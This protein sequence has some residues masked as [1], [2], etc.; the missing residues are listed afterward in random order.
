MEKTYQKTF[1]AGWGD[2]DFNSHMRNTAYLDKSAD[3]RMV[4]FSEHGF[5]M[6]EFVRLKIGPVII[7]DEMGIVESQ[8]FLAVS[9]CACRQRERLDPDSA[10]CRHPEEV[11]LHFKGLARYLVG[12]DLGRRIAQQDHGSKAGE[13]TCLKFKKI[14]VYMVFRRFGQVAARSNYYQNLLEKPG[15]THGRP[16]FPEDP[17]G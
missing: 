14:E 3:T 9:R 6:S 8:D 15:R 5:P 4:F 2:M 10:E 1:L 12:N 17:F 11:C 7:K 16:G 13:S